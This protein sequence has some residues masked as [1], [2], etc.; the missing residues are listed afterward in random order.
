MDNGV[1]GV[2]GR[3]RPGYADGAR[4]RIAVALNLVPAGAA[5]AL[6]ILLSPPSSWAQPEILGALAAIAVVASLAEVRLKTAAVAFFD[7]SI[8][9]ALIALAIAGPVPALL[10]WAIPAAISVLVMRRVPLLSPGV[11]AT[12][13]GYAFALLAAQTVLGLGPAVSPLA[14]VLL[15]FAAGLAMGLASFVFASLL[16]APFYEGYR[17]APLIRSEFIDLAPAVLPMLALA[18]LSWL[19]L[20][21]L[22][23]F[24]LAPL[25]GVVVLPQLAIAAVARARSVARLSPAEATKLYAAAIAD[26]LALERRE[27]RA[28]ALAAELPAREPP[29][30]V[31]ALG[32]E[33]ADWVG[34]LGRSL[35]PGAPTDVFE[36]QLMALRAHER[37]DGRDWPAGAGALSPAPLASRILACARA[38]SELTAAGTAQLP[39]A[40]ALAHLKA[41]A[42]AELDP[43]IVLAAAEV[44]AQE[45]AF[46]RSPDFQPRLHRLPL[47]HSVRRG[48]IP[49]LLSHAA[50]PA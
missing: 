45:E 5:L 19:L 42:G 8:A 15:L 1:R 30:G 12:L 32:C 41:R 47:P 31:Y 17:L 34:A 38:W 43:A 37:F 6:F 11:V 16:I 13:T 35:R 33:L 49:A 46:V 27:R 21:P 24:A 2:L 36:A 48:A 20:G 18:S 22:G 4:A 39:H 28:L 25:A 9:L 26:L 40:E 7:P 44:V 23:A 3:W 10:I 14:G 50:E 29:V